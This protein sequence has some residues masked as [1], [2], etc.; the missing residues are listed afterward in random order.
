MK[1]SDCYWIHLLIQWLLFLG[2][3]NFLFFYLFFDMDG[4]EIVGHFLDLERLLVYF[5]VEK[6]VNGSLI[7]AECVRDKGHIYFGYL[8][9][10]KFVPLLIFKALY[11]CVIMATIS[12][13]I[14]YQYRIQLIYQWSFLFVLFCEFLAL[15]IMIFNIFFHF[16]E[17]FLFFF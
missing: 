8:C 1:N 11:E 3:L 10:I 5:F 13:S 17:I 2:L 7:A 16:L 4:D 15:I 6:H 14:M 12:T 9:V